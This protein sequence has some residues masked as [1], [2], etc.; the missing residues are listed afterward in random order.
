MAYH[1]ILPISRIGIRSEL[2][3]LG[4]FNGDH[5]WTQEDLAAWDELGANPFAQSVRRVHCADLNGNGLLDPEDR[6]LLV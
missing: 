5:R 2:I 6:Q 3:M 4:D 1:W